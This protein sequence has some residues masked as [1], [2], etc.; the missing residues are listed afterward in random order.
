MPDDGSDHSRISTAADPEVVSLQNLPSSRIIGRVN[1]LRN[2]SPAMRRVS[3]AV[4][5]PPGHTIPSGGFGLFQSDGTSVPESIF[6]RAQKRRFNQPDQ[7]EI[8]GLELDRLEGLS[9]FLGPMMTHYGHFL[10]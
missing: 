9:Y 3:D 5:V 10:T 1:V 7:A 6:F 2:K 8:E 4:Y